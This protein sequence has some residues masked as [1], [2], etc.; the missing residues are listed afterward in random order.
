MSPLCC[1]SQNPPR[2]HPSCKGMREA[3]GKSH[4]CYWK[5]LWLHSLKKRITVTFLNSSLLNRPNISSA[6]EDVRADTRQNHQIALRKCTGLSWQ[7]RT[8]WITLLIFAVDFKTEICSM[9]TDMSKKALLSLNLK[10]QRC[11][12]TAERCSS[13]LPALS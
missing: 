8:L 12:I 11:K 4:F 9:K 3:Q 7:F 6:L 5:I 13:W 10:G 2:N 1:T